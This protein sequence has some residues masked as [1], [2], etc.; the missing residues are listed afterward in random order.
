MNDEN[1]RQTVDLKNVEEKFIELEN[2]SQ[3]QE[4]LR[5][6]EG[7]KVSQI[8]FS[9]MWLVA[10]NP[11]VHIEKYNMIINNPRYL[12]S[13]KSLVRSMAYY[14]QPAQA[15]ASTDQITERLGEDF[16]LT[17]RPS[18]RDDGIFF[19]IIKTNVKHLETVSHLYY[20][21]D[22]E[23]NIIAVPSFTEGTSQVM[24]NR[25][26][27]IIEAFRDPKSEFFIK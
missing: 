24:V 7:E 5:Q 6:K 21:H 19:L 25:N 20:L 1:Q 3:I 26:N 9:D 18:T 2:I 14:S 17:L 4:A 22:N 16:D 15:A 12:D 10:E 11:S 27:K 8:L 23:Y 13:F